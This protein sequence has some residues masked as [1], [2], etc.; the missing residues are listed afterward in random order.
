MKTCLNCGTSNLDTAKSCQ[1]CGTE[2]ETKPKTTSR[3]KPTIKSHSPE[4]LVEAL[5]LTAEIL[6]KRQADIMFVLDC[7]GSMEGEINAIK[8][9]I[10]EFA[11]TIEKD[12]VRVRVGLIEFRDRLINEEHRVL[13]INGEVFTNNPNLFRQEVSKL[14]AYGGG[15]AP[16]SSLDAVMF[17]LRQPFD[18]DSNKVIVLI[19]DAP[20]HIPDQE[21]Q[22]IEEVVREIQTVGID[23]FYLVI[24]TQ[25]TESK[26]YLKLLSGV[27]GMAFDLG[28]GDDFRSRADNFKRTLMSLGKTISTMTR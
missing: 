15:D 3:S 9:T 1:Q 13:K 19:T 6:A 10:M 23:Q 24:A 5:K 2:L 16:E 18:S 8:E 22:N 11:D 26:V 14:K 20:P 21:T 4:E 27:K 17:A 25:D 28:K 7:T 12:G